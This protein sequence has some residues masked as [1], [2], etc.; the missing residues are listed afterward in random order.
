[1]VSRGPERDRIRSRGL[2]VQYYCTSML[3]QYEYR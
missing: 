3:V 2:T 1:M